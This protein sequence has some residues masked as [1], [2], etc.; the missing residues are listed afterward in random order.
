[1]FEGLVD[2]NRDGSSLTQITI[3]PYSTVKKVYKLHDNIYFD[4]TNANL[5]LLG[6]SN[7]NITDIVGSTIYSLQVINRNSNTEVIVKRDSSQNLIQLTEN[8]Y[9]DNLTDIEKSLETFSVNV[10]AEYTLVYMSDDKDTYIHIINLITQKHIST[11][12]FSLSSANMYSLP[13]NTP[14]LKT[15]SEIVSNYFQ[16]IEY[17][18]FYNNRLLN[19]I[20]YYINYDPYN[21]YIVVN[22]S[23]GIMYYNHKGDSPVTNTVANSLNITDNTITNVMLK[24]LVL[25]NDNEKTMT[26]IIKNGFNTIACVMAY[27]VDNGV[28]SYY[29]KDVKRFKQFQGGNAIH[30]GN[31]SG[32]AIPG[33]NGNA[34]PG[35]SDFSGNWYYGGDNSVSDYYKNFF[36]SNFNDYILKTQIVPPVCPACPYCPSNSH[37][38]VCTSCGGNGGA[39]LAINGNSNLGTQTQNIASNIGT[40]AQNVASNV[41][42]NAKSVGDYI[43]SG[44]QNIASNVGNNAKTVGDYIGSSAQN[45]ASAVGS[46]VQNVVSAIGSNAKSVGD[47]IG[48]S[49]SNNNGYNGITNNGISNNGSFNNGDG[50]SNNYNGYEKPDYYNAYGALVSQNST[51]MPVTASFSA[52]SK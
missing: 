11:F 47:Y 50:I 22:I 52:F 27:T 20:T 38:S 8:M 21:A 44:A 31:T 46:N 23:G 26:V 25:L 3:P 6:S 5:I 39:G 28:S 41:G 32:N 24:T 4:N 12:Y 18:P 14:I 49:N 7:T 36:N 37:N 9:T 17:T 35:G 40:G 51:F 48:S 43:G 10:N 30:D 34:I 33:G 15:P 2:Y 13:D 45:V 19:K 29:P 42:S 1:V 16:P